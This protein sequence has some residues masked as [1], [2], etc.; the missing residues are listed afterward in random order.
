MTET[1]HENHMTNRDPSGNI[2]RLSIV[3]LNY[4]VRDFLEHLLTSLERAVAGIDTEIFVVDNASYDGSPDMV[5]DKFPDVRLIENRENLGFSKG[6]NIALEKCRG[7]YVL[8]VNPDVVVR[9]DTLSKM[10][11]FMDQHP[12]TGAATCKVL[13]ADGTLQLSCRRSF[14]TPMVAFWKITGFS[15]LFPKNRH[16]GKYNLTFQEENQTHETEAISGSFMF[17]RRKTI[18]EVGLLDERFFMYGEDLDWCY[19]IKKAGWKIFYHPETQII[20]YKGE[21]TK[22][23]GFDDIRIFYEAMALFV[24]KHFKPQYSFLVIS[25]LRLSIWLRASF[26]FLVRL[27]RIAFS[28]ITDILI[29]NISVSA[30]VLLR[31][32]DFIVPEWMP[33]KLFFYLG[34]HSGA[35]VIW[36]LCLAYFQNYT[37]RL[38]SVSQSFM[39]ALAGFFI[40]ST[41]TLFSK[42]FVFSRLTILYISS[43]VIVLIPGWRLVFMIVQRR[44]ASG[45]LLTKRVIK[46]NTVLVGT[47]NRTAEILS[48]L[49]SEFDHP[50][51]ILGIISDQND[52]R[53]K[54]F[55][56]YP[57]LGTL[58]GL[59]QIIQT[60]PVNEIIFSSGDLSYDSIIELI[61]TLPKD[62]KINFKIVPSDTLTWAGKSPVEKLSGFPVI[63]FE[64]AIS[65][66][67]ARVLKRTADITASLLLMP[68]LF[69]SFI[70]QWLTTSVRKKVIHI[71]ADETFTVWMNPHQKPL[72]WSMILQVLSGRLGLVGKKIVFEREN[73]LRMSEELSKIKGLK[74]GIY[75][76]SDLFKMPCSEELNV[77]DMYYCQNYSF[78]LDVEIFIRCLLQI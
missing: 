73:P 46:K 36:L 48:S 55:C 64:Y 59:K 35:T 32:H 20:H 24:E 16:F 72:L 62:K 34:I 50:Y 38:F 2:P 29:I 71:R 75:S 58:N 19:R 68:F 41:V 12:E 10:I 45:W 17:L 52:F 76:L 47:G 69:F 11:D 70:F 66:L 37:Q 31:Y 21:S 65:R 9:E 33:S 5:R 78:R 54:S 15:G 7:E 57:V 22:K 14:P 60:H 67:H 49:S 4:N 28:P 61:A 18:K 39:A 43:M 42:D 51:R 26:S 63:R 44:G 53:E 3:I 8:V 23:S 74:Y 77:T 27:F 13:N 56:E 40:V 6:N 30:G 25:L 1:H